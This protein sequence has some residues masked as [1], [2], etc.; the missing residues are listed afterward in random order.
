MA[1]R[2][3]AS[4][5]VYTSEKDLTYSIETLG[6]TTL[7]AAGE[8][9]KGPAFQPIPIKNYDQFSTFFGGVN[10]EKFKNTQIVKYELS[11]IAKNYL[12]QSNQL[13]VTRIL[14]LSGYDKGDAFVLKTIGAI[15]KT[16]MTPT[17]STGIT[18][19]FTGTTTGT[20][21][22]VSGSGTNLL[23]AIGINSGV[24][25]SKFASAYNTYFSKY[26]VATGTTKN[27]W[28]HDVFHYGVIPTGT[29]ATVLGIATSPTNTST[30]SNTTPSN[31]DSYPYPTGLPSSDYNNYYI[32]TEFNY[33]VSPDNYNGK[34][35]ILTTNNVSVTGSII[36]NNW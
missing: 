33:N 23:T 7:G 22:N 10:P 13:Y 29:T 20:V 30:F 28:K 25:T 12:S 32:N 17:I 2:V 8:T 16:T 14:G 35:F 3:Y 27:F 19:N 9:V 15:D 11:Y 6:I 18:I 26:T 24:D 36:Y 31:V 4:P 21:Y 5:G 34:S 1:N